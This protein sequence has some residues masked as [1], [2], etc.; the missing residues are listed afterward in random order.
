MVCGKYTYKNVKLLPT[1]SSCINP[2][3]LLLRKEIPD[4]SYKNKRKKIDFTKI[5]MADIANCLL[6]KQFF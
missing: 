1:L 4:L 5:I 2:L 6:K 3:L